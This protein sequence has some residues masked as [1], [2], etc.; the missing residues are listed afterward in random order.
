ML[1]VTGGLLYSFNKLVTML[2]VAGGLPHSSLPLRWALR[3]AHQ[4]MH[5]TWRC[6]RNFVLHHTAVGEA[7]GRP[8]KGLAFRLAR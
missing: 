1:S 4:R 3:A 6:R 2:S 8:G 5:F 7:A